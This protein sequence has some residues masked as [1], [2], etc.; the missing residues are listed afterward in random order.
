MTQTPFYE[1]ID[2]PDEIFANHVAADARGKATAPI[3]KALRSRE[4]VERWYRQLTHMKRAAEVAIVSDRAERAERKVD[5]INDPDGRENWL[6]YIAE[7]ERWAAKNAWFM[8]GVEDKIAEAQRIRQRPIKRVAELE[9][10]IRRHQQEMQ[11]DCS[12]VDEE[13]WEVLDK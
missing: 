6:R 8:A 11:D 3:S 7:R 2:A 5:M 10:A 13:L 9:R 12:P 4:C 1:I